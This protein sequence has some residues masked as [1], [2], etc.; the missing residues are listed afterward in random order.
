MS[1]PQ[2]PTGYYITAQ[3][4]AALLMLSLSISTITESGT[5]DP[6][7]LEELTFLLAGLD[8]IVFRAKKER[9]SNP[10]PVK[11]GEQEPINEDIQI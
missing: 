10:A 5:V 8:D 9:L 1:K 3:D 7:T 4:M 2:N 6:D 11:A